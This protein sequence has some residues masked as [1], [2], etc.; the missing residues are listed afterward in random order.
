MDYRATM[1]KNIS[2][3]ESVEATDPRY[4][5]NVELG[6]H[7]YTAVDAYYRFKRATEKFGVFGIGWGVKNECY[8][9]KSVEGL[10]IYT[11]DMYI[12]LDSATGL[13]PI[14]SAIPIYEK[15]RVYVNKQWDGKTY[16]MV[17]DDDFIKK[18]VTDAITKGL[19]MLGFSADVFLGMFED[20]KYVADVSAEMGKISQPIE[21]ELREKL[22]KCTTVVEVSDVFSSYPNEERKKKVFRDIVSERLAELKKS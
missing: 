16:E 4:T 5:N 7:K 12:N 19:S 20:N 2:L 13:F 15:K 3:W 11:A 9:Y 1:N 6:G 22:S 8:D 14:R 10:C 17:A 18:V 21:A